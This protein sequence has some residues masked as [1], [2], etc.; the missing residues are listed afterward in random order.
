MKPKL[1][2]I[3]VLSLS[4]LSGVSVKAQ[5]QTHNPVEGDE[6]KPCVMIVGAVRKPARFAL[7]KTVRLSELIARAG[8]LA[9]AAGETVQVVHSTMCSCSLEL[10]TKNTQPGTDGSK[11]YDPFK[12]YYLDELKNG[13]DFDPTIQPGDVVIVQ[14]APVVYV[15]GNV[16]KPQRLYLREP[17]TVTQAIALA[18]GMLKNSV[19]KQ[20]RV[21]RRTRAS[22][23][24]T[25]IAVNLE[26]V[27]KGL[28][29]VILQPYDVIEVPVKGNYASPPRNLTAASLSSNSASGNR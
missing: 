25:V 11:L 16:M 23:N 19:P 3:V 2:L 1:F 29:D 12:V 24:Q 6:Q 20:V 15:V 28:A 4:S 21:F 10:V 22:G 27:K 7:G 18:G 8:G 14:E 13:N 5:N 9:E 26:K 17:L